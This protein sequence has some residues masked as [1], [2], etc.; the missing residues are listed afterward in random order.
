MTAPELLMDFLPYYNELKLGGHL[1]CAFLAS[2][3]SGTV[4][5]CTLL[6]AGDNKMFERSY[7]FALWSSALIWVFPMIID[8]SAQV[9]TCLVYA[10]VALCVI[11]LKYVFNKNARTAAVLWTVFLAA[12]AA[13]FFMLYKKVF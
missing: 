9:R 7:A 1:A 5:F 2:I 11:A 13:V 6:A 10:A 3:I 4:V 12:Q 8:A